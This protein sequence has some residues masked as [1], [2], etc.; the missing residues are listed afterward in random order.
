MAGHELIAYLRAASEAAA[1]A[2]RQPTDPRH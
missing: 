2:K 1:N